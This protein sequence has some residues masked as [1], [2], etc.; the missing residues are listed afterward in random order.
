MPVNTNNSAEAEILAASARVLNT[1]VTISEVVFT[2]GDTLKLYTE[3]PTQE[4]AT[5]DAAE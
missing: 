4:E 2:N 5:T 1:K 3:L